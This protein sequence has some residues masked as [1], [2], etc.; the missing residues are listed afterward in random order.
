MEMLIKSTM[1]IDSR[2]DREQARPRN[3][4]TATDLLDSRIA[5][6]GAIDSQLCLFAGGEPI[7]HA[8]PNSDERV[9]PHQQDDSDWLRAY[10]GKP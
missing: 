3:G 1:A 10:L 9:P 6:E 5:T 7:H 2:W 4:R 8:C